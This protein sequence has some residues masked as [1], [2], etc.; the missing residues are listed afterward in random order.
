MGFD[1]TRVHLCRPAD[2]SFVVFVKTLIGKTLCLTATPQMSVAHFKKLIE[3][4][5]GETAA[6]TGQE[7]N[8]WGP[9]IPHIPQA[10]ATSRLPA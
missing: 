8:P 1:W 6:D 9:Y 10:H 5:E 2:T 3:K 4:K 7:R